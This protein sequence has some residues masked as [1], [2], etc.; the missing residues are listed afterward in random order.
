MDWPFTALIGFVG[1][2]V[3]SLIAPWVHW[4]IEKQR[5]K[6]DYKRNLIHEWRNWIEEFYWDDNDDNFGDSAVYAAMRPHMRE[7]VIKKLEAQRTLH[8]PPE[9]GRGGNIAKQLVSDEIA[10]IEGTWELV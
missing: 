10:H 8:V 7:E 2:A 9:G 5:A 1:G 6:I 3:G 4:A